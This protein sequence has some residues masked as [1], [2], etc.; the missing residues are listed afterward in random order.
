[1]LIKL[2]RVLK[3]TL[4]T[5][6]VIGAVLITSLRLLLPQLNNYR[7]PITAWL[8][9]ETSL[10]I[11]VAQ[12]EGRWHNLGP[13]MA[14]HGV[15]LGQNS[16]DMI[17]AREIDLELDLWQS[18]L[19]LKP[20]FRDVQI[21]GLS[22]DFT[23]LP[24]SNDATD[25]ARQLDLARI[26]QVLFVQLGT[27]SLRDATLVV[28]SPAG[29][30]QPVT[31][32]ELKW[33]RRGGM[34]LAEGVVSIP[35]TDL[36]QLNVVANLSAKNGLPSLSGTVYI[37]TRNLSFTPWL[38]Q[39]ILGGEKITD[40]QINTEV[41]LTLENGR[42]SHSKV[43]FQ[44]SFVRWQ[45]K[46]VKHELALLRGMLSL[47]SVTQ[48]GAPGWRLD[49]H[50]L[51]LATDEKAWPRL[52]FAAQ[53]LAANGHGQALAADLPLMGTIRQGSWQLAVSNIE[54]ARLHPLST[55]LPDENAARQAIQTLQPAGLLKDLRFAG[56]GLA[57]PRFSLTLDSVSNKQWMYLPAFQNLN[58]TVAG[59]A[60]Q[61]QIML[62][63]AQQTLDY[64]KVF[65]APMKIDQADV[66]A[67]WQQDEQGWR[68]WSDALS[69]STPHLKASGQFRLDFPANAPSWLSFYGE[70]EL[71]DA[72]AAWR[73][74]PRPA[75]G[76]QLTDYLS[77]AIRGG[78]SEHAQLLWYGD[79]PAFPYAHHDGNF[80]VHVPLQSGRFSFDTAWPELTDLD[81]DLVFRNDRMLIDA[82]H[83]KTKGAIA[84]RVTG[85][86]WLH[87]D[88][89]LKLD[90]E[91]GAQGELVRDY[92]MAT[93]L[94]DSVGAALTAVQVEGPVN[95]RLL[96]DIPFSGELVHAKGE[97]IL[98]NN[99]VTIESLAL[100]L[101]QVKGKIEFS[102]DQI[103]A[104]NMTAYWLGQPLTVSFDG[105]S[106]ASGYQVSVDLDGVWQIPSL[107][108]RLQDPLLAQ[109]TGNS[110]WHG[111]VGVVLHDTG[112]DYQVS[113]QAPLKGIRSQLPYPLTLVPGNSGKA[114]LT[115]AG[116]TS[117]LEASLTVPDAQYKAEIL[118][119]PTPEIV[120]SGL[121]IGLSE[122]RSLPK[123]GHDIRIQANRVDAD[124]WEALV[125]AIMAKK[126]HQSGPALIELPLPTRVN[127]RIQQL[128]LA[129]L[130]WHDLELAVRKQPSQWHAVLGSR[131][132]SGE[133][134]WPDKQPL[135][136]NLEQFHLNL[137]EGKK[138][139]EPIASK[140]KYVPQVSIPPVTDFDRSM[141]TY[142]P[143]MDVKVKDL[144]LQGYR[145][146]A[147]SGRLRREDQT[148]ILEELQLDSGTTSLS[149][150][151]HW[152]MSQYQNETQIAFDISG[153]D[154]SELM[155]RLG[156][157]GG[158]QDASFKSYASIQWQG[159]PWSMH[160][161]T[162]TG[163]LKT[164]TG[165]G[166]IRDVGGAGRI[167]GLF[168]LDS[169]IRKMQ[170][171]FTGVFD[172]GMAFDYIKGSGR[173]ENG[174]FRTDDVEMKALAGDMYIQGSANLVDETV[175]A[176][177]KFIPD[178]T[179]GIP[180]LTAFAVAPQTAIVVFAI[181]TALSPVVDVFTQINYVV[182]G[183]IESPIVTEQSRFT[184]EFKV[185]E[186]LKQ[187]ATP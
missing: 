176:R 58:A 113:I 167:L 53:W 129:G 173:I 15:R 14:L 88:G 168:S 59:D 122:R 150:D 31:L 121:S 96:L 30:R 130:N 72:G 181:S 131:E 80:E 171:D 76:Q 2:T 86:A 153:E 41:W 18:L 90:M 45:E 11:G 78:Q 62:D 69:V 27:F 4:L 159:A 107:Q 106:A 184:G 135:K 147:L 10:Q 85:D 21:Y 151:G 8:S 156:V 115:A 119:S 82:R 73:Y 144:W 44:D 70:T 123:K 105:A 180:V 13:V 158:I 141:M 101:S 114:L 160:R 66:R 93:P 172:D 154:S 161:E 75:L 109:M 138:P 71:K 56:Q 47:S 38:N 81:L 42:L 97:A 175:N 84:Q 145:L 110:R 37:R 51:V 39:A 155:G 20:V 136:I 174:L 102:D 60:H 111:N 164:E 57:V 99:D 124:A 149:L 7:A 187:Q 28:T 22:L 43:R 117:R 64:D 163:E 125:Q 77:A 87:P 67:F 61:G 186:S 6:L 162:L 133:L 63:V 35:G 23:Q 54:L 140:R 33:D 12:V 178:L 139:L 170:L 3:W 103:T 112:L 182:S 100:P 128:K 32:K 17:Q 169:I 104:Q 127:A 94:V 26:E 142:L 68:I 143:E 126:Q 120:R 36:N 146:G 185:P 91:V 83:A 46:G 166:V 52:D 89:H 98:D 157:S 74:L 25:S 9:E 137:P 165:K 183:P 5:L 48:N 34:H 116:N 16:H 40:S 19:N 29:H 50:K 132:V 49:S 65:Q 79:L 152:T 24:A 179:S 95:A 108:Q 118:L 1:M 148:L 177:V 92:M 134:F 55:L